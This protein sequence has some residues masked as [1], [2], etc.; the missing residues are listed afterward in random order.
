ME[1]LRDI[2]LTSILFRRSGEAGGGA[3]V[4][5]ATQAGSNGS[6]L[7]FRRGEGEREEFDSLP[8]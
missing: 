2:T 6:P 1:W 5:V 8:Q 3:R 4:R 7:L